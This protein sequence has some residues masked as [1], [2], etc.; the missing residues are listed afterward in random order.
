MATK[1]SLGRFV[2]DLPH[3]KPGGGERR[4]EKHGNYTEEIT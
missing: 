2:L 4:G 3:V 1:P